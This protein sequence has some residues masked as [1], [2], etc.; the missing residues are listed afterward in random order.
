[1]TFQLPL[2]AL[3]ALLGVAA[4]TAAIG[5]TL[6]GDVRGGPGSPSTATASYPPDGAN[7]IDELAVTKFTK[8]PV[9][10]YQVRSTKETL[11]AWQMKPQLPPSPTRPRDI[12]ILVDT[13]ASQAGRPLQQARQIVHTLSSGLTA[14]DRISVW[15]L[16]TPA[17]TRALTQDFQP[18]SSEDVRNA[19]DAL[20]E[21]EYGSGAT[22]L[23]GG[24]KQ[25]LDTLAP[26]RGRQQ[27][28]LLLGDG[29]SAF[30]PVSEDDRIAI[31]TRMD[32]NDFLFF[33]V[34]LG[35]KVDAHNLHGLAALTGGAVVRVQEDLSKPELR[36]EFLGRL[37]AALDSPVFK[38]EKSSFGAEVA[39]IFPTKLPPL[40]GDKATLV[41]GKLANKDMKKVTAT[42]TGSGAGRPVT[43]NLSQDLPPSQSDHFFLNMMVHQWREAPHKEAP[44]VLQADRA[45]ALASTQVKLYR[46]EFLTQA[47]WAVTMDRLDEAAK[48]YTAA[49]R[50]DPNDPEA[51]TGL[52]LVNKMKT[53][54]LTKSDLEKRI[55]EKADALKLDKNGAARTVIQDIGG[56][57]GAGG[58]QPPV[59][60]KQP[61]PVPGAQPPVPGKTPPGAAPPAPGDLIREAEALRRIEEQRYRVLVDSTIRRARQLLRTDPDQAYQDLK[62]Q[63]DEILAYGGIGEA[64]RTQLVADLN[65]VMQEIFLK[66]A[67]IKRQA[68]E[69]R[70][71]IARVRQRLNEFERL[72]LEEDRT[73]ARIDAFRQLMQQARY[74]LAYQ[75]AQLMIQERISRGQAVPPA[76]TASYIIGQ[77]ATQLREWRELVRIREDRFLLAMMQTEKS[78]IPYPDEPP[79]H[80][81]P[82]AVW[83]ELTG[84]RKERYENSILGPEASPTQKK[85]Q[86]ILEND[87]ISYEKDLTTTPLP[88]VLGD[89]ARRFD[90]TFVINKTAF[91]QPAALDDARATNLG[92]NR[93]DG[94]TLGTF[95]D[96]YLRGLS[97]NDV[98][99]IVRPDYIEITSYDKR[100]SEKVTRVF[101]VADLVI[102]IPAAVNQ[103]TLFQNLNVQQQTLAI[104]GQ[105]SL[106]GGGLQNFLGGGGGF[107]GNPFAAGGGGL[108]PGGGFGG[109]GGQDAGNPF[110]GGQNQG[111]I[112]GL[113]GNGG[114]GQFGNLG[115]QFGL[116]GSTQEG[117]L[118]GL[119][120]ETVAKGEWANVP[121]PPG[122]PTG[123]GE[124]SFLPLDQQNSLGYYPPAYAL[125]VRGTSRY[126]SGSSIKLKKRDGFAAAPARNNDPL[127]IGPGFKK[128]EPAANPNPMR[129]PVAAKPLPKPA[130][131]EAVASNTKKPTLVDPKVDPQ[132][133]LDQL[134]RKN[135]KR[136][137]NQAVDRAVTN[138]TML[139]GAAVIL[140]EMNE[141]GHAAEV[142]KA[143]LRKGLATD[144]WVHE[145]LVIALQMS[146]ASPV[147]VERAALSAMDLDSTDPKAYL[148]AAK[149]E[150]DLSNHDQAVVFCKRAAEFGPDQPGPYANALA[151]AELAK[152]V[153]P[154]TVEWAA[155]NLLRRDWTATDGVDYHSKTRDLLHKF[156][157]RFAAAGV[158]ADGLQK[159]VIEETQR[160]LVIELGWQGAADLDL[161]VVEPG[162]SVC[163]TTQK[164]STGG[165]VLKG[166]LIAQNSDAR[167]E[168]YIAAT[169][170]SGTYKVTVKPAFGSVAGSTAQLRVTKFKGTPRESFD[171]I[172]VDLNGSKPVEIPLEGGSRTELARVEADVTE[173][174][175]EPTS[176]NGLGKTSSGFGGGLGSAGSVMSAPVAGTAGALQLPPVAAP[177]DKVLR[178]LGSA[179]DIRASY[180]LNPDRQSYSIHVTPVFSTTVGDVKLPKVAL[181]PGGE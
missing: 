62:R 56:Q 67:E 86:S 30:D 1:M 106:Y 18:A 114:L 50:I 37:K 6:F 21:T 109:G 89:L 23:K 134:D 22:D 46:D 120:F 156:V 54:Q 169:A 5:T 77:H 60:G 158:K 51:G 83:R 63:R 13:S 179:A 69:E 168:T 29:Q 45:L 154:D 166:D 98:T 31:G 64:A 159:A 75:E 121:P 128:P 133:I 90:I 94:L 26:N 148:K 84:L 88:E 151:Y 130:D 24:L 174:R 48:L 57:P 135:P 25:A 93:L 149:V 160:D 9:L 147:E 8:L 15:T 124:E 52:E 12:L 116:Q 129:N 155:S 85:L 181:L 137:W 157:N 32:Q 92:A 162:G 131:T 43:L 4:A 39:E 87:R 17:A 71:H 74:E 113:G 65:A 97:V 103:Q 14:D 136:M 2:R 167:S 44:A 102:P 126:H 176:V 100:L 7:L 117:L 171:L 132:V 118:M 42:L 53:G 139:F 175:V 141:Y 19:A 58:A 28:V 70:E 41:M 10:T 66:G 82:A 127:V 11:F 104:F 36:D 101:P 76:A 178:G 145:A 95:L 143:N 20:V 78:H 165:G 105:A 163:S 173:L 142:I 125:I 16:S 34:P 180:K 72:Q 33:A 110:F 170:F 3:T 138:P 140:F 49:Q 27:V 107:G 146:K 177:R 59:P 115:G 172:T 123:E 122:D 38:A 99:Y 80:F 164:R 112:V 161:T 35:I 96:I 68:A 152:E 111:G 73:K 55:A 91:E 144:D 119:I 153:T 108:P 150:A 79:V 81:P 61:P 47:A 40:R